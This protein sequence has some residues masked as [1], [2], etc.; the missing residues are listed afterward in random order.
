MLGVESVSI[1]I[2]VLA[3]V[4]SF[5]SPCVLPL[6][7]SYLSYITG[8]SLDE[9]SDRRWVAFSHSLFFV[10]GFSII[11]IGLGASATLIGRLLNFYSLWLERAGGVLIIVFGLY[12]IGA[13][14][15][16]GFSRERRFHLQNKPIG[17]MGSMLV[18]IAFGAG[19]TPCIGPILGS[20]LMYSGSQG[21][22]TQG[23]VLLGG[24]SLGLAI[25]FVVAAVAVDRFLDWFKKYKKFIPLTNKIAGGIMIAMGLLL[26]TGYFSILAGWLQNLTPEFI[27]SRL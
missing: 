18:G 9:V 10:S 21:N 22:V 24:Y 13:F 1:S 11:F 17:Y 8:M 23:L 2:A 7:P 25:P 26:L 19:W 16:G 5:M 20:I 6:V 4:L 14:N 15:F 3:G 12:L 27:R